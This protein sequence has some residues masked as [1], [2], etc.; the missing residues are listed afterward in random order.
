MLR[1]STKSEVECAACLH[2]PL[3][4][5]SYGQGE[6]VNSPP[7]TPV[8]SDQQT[9][10]PVPACKAA[11]ST[12]FLTLLNSTTTLAARPENPLNVHHSSLRAQQHYSPQLIQQKH[13]SKSQT[14]QHSEQMFHALRPPLH[15]CS[16]LAT[17]TSP[18]TPY[19]LFPSIYST[20]MTN[21]T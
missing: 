12:N 3:K 11:I 2:L 18:P 10:P 6:Q 17:I 21:D 5:A 13:K 9:N 20:T 14:S 4:V 7:S 16:T 15:F 8:S 1:W 19:F